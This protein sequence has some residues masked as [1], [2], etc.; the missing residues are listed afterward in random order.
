MVVTLSLSVGCSSRTARAPDTTAQTT[1]TTS[2]AATSAATTTQPPGPAPA[3]TANPVG[4]W[5]GT[6]LCT[7]HPS[8]CHDE[9][10]VYRITRI[11][12]SDSLSVDARKIVNGEED[13]MGILGC[14]V[15]SGT[16]FR[17]DISNG[18]WSFE[19]RQDSLI[20]DMRRP[21]STKVRDVRAARSR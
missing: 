18:V 4:V 8:P 7:E 5:R 19:V 15:L 16:R 1:S 21:D 11:N 3:M 6:S 14:R 2:A 10:T 17:C 20:G 12:D 9:I 13:A